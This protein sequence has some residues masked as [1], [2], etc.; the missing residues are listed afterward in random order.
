MKKIQSEREEFTDFVFSCVTAGQHIKIID[1]FGP[2]T[3]EVAKNTAIRVEEETGADTKVLH[4]KITN[5]FESGAVLSEDTFLEAINSIMATDNIINTIIVLERIGYF[6]ENDIELTQRTLDFLLQAKTRGNVVVFLCPSDVKAFP[7]GIEELTRKVIIPL[8]DSD[9]L[10]NLVCA[11]EASLI[12]QYITGPSAEEKQKLKEGK[13]VVNIS[14][15]DKWKCAH[16]LLGMPMIVSQDALRV[17]IRNNKGL[18][19]KLP[20]ILVKEKIVRLGSLGVAITM[21]TETLADLGGLDLLK[22]AA[23]MIANACTEV[24]REYNI[25]HPTTVLLGG[26]TGTGKT[27]AVQVLANTT[28]KP[29]VAFGST[30][31]SYLGESEKKVKRIL[32]VARRLNGICWI[33]EIEKQFG[34]DGGE[35]TGGTSG[36]ILQIMLTEFQNNA[37][38]ARNPE[39]LKKKGCFLAVATSN[40]ISALPVEFISRW[41]EVYALDLPNPTERREVFEIHLKKVGVNSSTVALTKLVAMTKGYTS[42]E[43]SVICSNAHS[44]AFNDMYKAGKKELAVTTKYLETEINNTASMSVTCPEQIKAQREWC[45]KNKAKRASTEEAEVVGLAAVKM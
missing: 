37:N 14:E 17:S 6:L 19:G 12:D 45:I 39:Q 31:E 28:N 35:R 36:Q 25:K 3:M 40:N 34:G 18:S 7:D 44:Q 24:A 11:A 2:D 30:R 26:V 22:S 5:R 16:A 8:P 41:E 33:D 38:V 43:I 10:Y 13:V 4:Y 20:D 27:L 42:R 32:D 9:E 29:V 1:P 23:E 15:G 21:P